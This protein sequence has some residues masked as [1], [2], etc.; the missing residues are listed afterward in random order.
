MQTIKRKNSDT[1]LRP[2]HYHS[3]QLK[4]TAL[5]APWEGHY[6][7]N[8]SSLFDGLLT[9]QGNLEENWQNFHLDDHNYIQL[10]CTNCIWNFPQF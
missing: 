2:L 10:S 3:H 5:T 9:I 1:P 4:V 8:F 6:R 7:D